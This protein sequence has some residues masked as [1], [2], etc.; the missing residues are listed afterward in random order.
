M[1]EQAGDGCVGDTVMGIAYSDD[2]DDGDDDQ[3]F[4]ICQ[5][6]FFLN[7]VT[8]PHCGDHTK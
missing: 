7:E 3:I 1:D 8:D 4:H 2:E 5:A 6:Y